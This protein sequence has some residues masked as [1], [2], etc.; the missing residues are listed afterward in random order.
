L[1]IFI[2]GDVNNCR[3]I[4]H[5]A[6]DEGYIAGR[7]GTS[8]NID[9]YCRRTPLHIVFSDPQ[10][11]VVGRSYQQLQDEQKRFVTGKIDFQDQSRAI[12]EQQN[13]GL[14][15]VYAEEDTGQILGA[16][17]VC[18]EAEH[19]AHHLAFAVQHEL[20]I[21][22]MLENPY[23]HPTVEEGLRTALQD[24]GRQLSPA[25]GRGLSLCDCRPESPLC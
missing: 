24:A 8:D 3:P 11:A 18:P 1:P 6:I 4:L 21:L 2:A 10:I 23:Y 7:N 17:L 9:C 19:L 22:D 14:L 12:L 16:E 20:T 5:E 15:H 25:I 13:Q